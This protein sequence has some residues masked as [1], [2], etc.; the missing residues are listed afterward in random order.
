[1]TK[2]V[3]SLILTLIIAATVFTGCAVFTQDKGEEATL[4]S[5]S[6]SIT[7]K[8]DFSFI[9]EQ[10]SNAQEAKS[11]G[12]ND[13][14]QKNIQNPEIDI[15]SYYG[16]DDITV[17][18]SE[19]IEK[20]LSVKTSGSVT[21]NSEVKDVIL[22][23]A[24]RGFTANAKADSIIVKG[25]E[26]TCEIKSETGA[27]YIMGK[28]CVV[29]VHN[30]NIAKIFARNSTAVINNYSDAGFD[31]TL[32]NGTKVTVEKGKSYDVKNNIIREAD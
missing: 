5:D 31:V 30:S 27:L 9:D 6:D 16:A 7:V 28:D 22:L 8:N 17:E 21:L 29:N 12:T 26:I 19:K 24:A 15:A 2:K 18:Y 25:T 3:L 14:F 11:A 10:L 1:M 20:T 23:D 32:T 13:A 4:K